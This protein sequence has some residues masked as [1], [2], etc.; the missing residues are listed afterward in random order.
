MS[1]LIVLHMKS[2]PSAYRYFL[3]DEK[4]AISGAQPIEVYVVCPIRVAL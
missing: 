3:F 1:G 4:Y 2:I